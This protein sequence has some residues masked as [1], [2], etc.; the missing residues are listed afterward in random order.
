[1]TDAGGLDAHDL[2]PAIP[3]AI[4]L[5]KSSPGALGQLNLR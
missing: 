4:V 2:V 1:M 5:P 3:A